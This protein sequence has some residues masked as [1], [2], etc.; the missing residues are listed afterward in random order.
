MAFKQLEYLTSKKYYFQVYLL[1]VQ[2]VKIKKQFLI[3]VLRTLQCYKVYSLHS[4]GL[5]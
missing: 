4:E 5:S 2:A 3:Q 1:Q